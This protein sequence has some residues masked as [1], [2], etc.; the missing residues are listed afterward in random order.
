MSRE[1][2]GRGGEGMKEGQ[3]SGGAGKEEGSKL[4]RLSA[5]GY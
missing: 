4:K 1:G 3:Q 5:T 2:G